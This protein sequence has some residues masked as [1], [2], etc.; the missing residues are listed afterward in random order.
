MILEWTK[1]LFYLIYKGQFLGKIC[2]CLK[3][4]LGNNLLKMKYWTEIK[5]VQN[6]NHYLGYFEEGIMGEVM[7]MAIVHLVEATVMGVMVAALDA[8]D[9]VDMATEDMA[10]EGYYV[11]D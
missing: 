1:F 5:E 6:L 7:A 10:M 8:E 9:M 4:E 11:L 2:T 3:I